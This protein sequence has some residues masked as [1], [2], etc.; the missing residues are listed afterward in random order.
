ML[1]ILVWIVALVAWRRTRPRRTR[2][3]ASGV[4]AWSALGDVAPVSATARLGARGRGGGGGCVRRTVARSGRYPPREPVEATQLPV[5]DT[6]STAWYCPGVPASFPLSDQTFALSNLG[7][8]PARAAVTV[9]PDDGSAPVTRML[10]VAPASVRNFER[11]IL[12]SG[13]LVIEPFSSEVV[14]SAGLES[15]EQLSTV[16]CRDHRGHRLVLRGGHHRP[17]CRPMARARRS[18]RRRCPR[19]CRPAH[20]CRT[21]GAAVVD[22]PR[23]SRP[24]PP[25][26]PD[27]R[28]GG[29]T[30]PRLG[31]S[32]RRRR[33]SRRRRRRFSTA[34]TTGTPGVA[35]SI[36]AVKPA[37]SWWF[38][39]GDT[40]TGASAVV[41]IANVGRLDAEVSVQ[42]Q[43]RPRRSC[44]RSS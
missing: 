32:A 20:R 15:A 31:R 35:T 19:R 11:R 9:H 40:R 22:G 41:A 26:H 27:P 17:R 7:S 43:R 24:I 10:T 16:P 36:G 5:G 4:S 14:V 1:E 29:A 44:L 21:P 3:G 38:T 30:R 25:G 18:V 8:R 13:P 37:S 28:P 39:G 33:Q 12:P 23:R 6:L 2:G 42:G 34:R